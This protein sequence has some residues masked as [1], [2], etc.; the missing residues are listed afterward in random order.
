MLKKKHGKDRSK[1]RTSKGQG[2]AGLAGHEGLL[3]DA[4]GAA[5]TEGP[6]PELVKAAAQAVHHHVI[7]A[8]A[9][10]LLHLAATHTMHMISHMNGLQRWSG[11]DELQKEF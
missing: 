1:G 6:L 9:H 7:S 8:H 2:E 5:H 4:L 11:N 10:E 3:L